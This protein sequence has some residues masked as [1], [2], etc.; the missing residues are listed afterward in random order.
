MSNLKKTAIWL[1]LLA[2]FVKISGFIRESIIARQFGA[3]DYTDGYLLAFSFI[4]LVLA[5]ISGGF[6]NV[7]LPLYIK[8]QKEDRIKAEKNANSLM[9]ITF[10]IFFVIS[11]AGYFY[12]PSIVPFIYGN[13]TPLA[14]QIAIEITQIFFLAMS[15]IA[16]SAILDSYLQSRRIFVPSQIA[17]LL[18]TLTGAMFALI[19][20]DIWGIHSLAYGFVFGVVLGLCLQFFYLLRSGYKWTP[21]VRMERTFEKTFIVLLVPALL[22]SV[23]GQINMFVNKRFASDTIEGAVTYLNNSSLLVSIPHTIY[24]TT[25]AVIIFTLLSEQV[26]QKEKFQNTFFM[27]L[28]ISFV[29]LMPVAVGLFLVGDAAISFVFERGKFTA[30]DTHNTYIALLF[31]LPII[32]TQ[33]LQYIVSKSMYAQGKTSIILR[34]SVT[35]IVL[36][37]ILNY[38]FVKPFGYPGLALS[39]SLVSLYYLSISTLFVYKDFDKGEAKK[40]FNMMI[41]VTPAVIVM[42]VPILLLKSL[43]PIDEL[44]SLLQLAL[45]IPLGILLYSSSLYVFYREGFRQLLSILRKKKTV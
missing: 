27:G 11:G 32:V 12:A 5:M 6:N 1:T 3:S 25:I 16:L 43:T 33:G 26:A 39:S 35:T 2:L 36:N 21:T 38:L 30:E 28:Q 44:Y 15:F 9:N 42:A 4:T 45:F 7:F 41:R 17:K 18:Q 19:F 37:I 34:I 10:I 40:L 23:V 8:E 13:T 14:G 31:Y 24:G 29:T 20:S 22:N